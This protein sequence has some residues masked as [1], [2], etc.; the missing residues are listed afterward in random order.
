M[1]YR[2]FKDLS[3][4]N[5]TLRKY[6]CMFIWS[7]GEEAFLR[8]IPQAKII[9]AWYT[10]L[11]KNLKL[12]PTPKWCKLNPMKISRFKTGSLFHGALSPWQHVTVPS[13]WN[14]SSQTHGFHL[15]KRL[16]DRRCWQ[17]FPCLREAWR[18][19]GRQLGA[20][21][22][23]KDDELGG[24][25]AGFKVREPRERS[26]LEKAVGAF[27]L[28]EVARSEGAGLAGKPVQSPEHSVVLTA[29]C[30]ECHWWLQGMERETVCPPWS[31][32]ASLA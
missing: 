11:S 31:P 17:N 8:M 26:E 21:R 23:S 27:V 12:L 1:K 20:A 13:S 25:R 32:G 3:V 6:Q 30:A 7:W 22:R 16:R 9:K 10:E 18:G 2:E 4:K 29:Q 19:P 5:E 28:W 14:L 15:S 24:G